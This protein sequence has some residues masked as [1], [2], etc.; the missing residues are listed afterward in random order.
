MCLGSDLA[1]LEMWAL[2][3]AHFESEER[4]LSNVLRNFGQLI[5]PSNYGGSLQPREAQKPCDPS[6][7]ADVHAWCDVRC[8]LP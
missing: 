7:Y 5:A 3:T 4:A 6:Y 2:F 8:A 1:R